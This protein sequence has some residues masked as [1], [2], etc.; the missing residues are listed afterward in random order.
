MLQQYGLKRV[1]L[2]LRLQSANLLV[3]I[4]RTSLYSSV[5][6]ISIFPEIL[7]DNVN[8][9]REL[10]DEEK[11]MTLLSNNF[12]GSGKYLIL[13]GR[14]TIHCIFVHYISCYE[15]FPNFQQEIIRYCRTLPVRELRA[16]PSV[17]QR[18]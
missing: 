15:V 18:C 8:K 16:T 1:S 3:I 13:F 6:Y 10:V 5:I 14:M 2:L 9:I 12:K 17:K 7:S 11:G 4:I